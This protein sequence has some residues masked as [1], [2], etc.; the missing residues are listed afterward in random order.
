MVVTGGCSGR[1]LLDR[2]KKPVRYKRKA[3]ITCGANQ[4]SINP[5]NPQPQYSSWCDTINC[6]KRVFNVLRRKI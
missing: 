3:V 6:P 4:C 5:A 1:I 2:P